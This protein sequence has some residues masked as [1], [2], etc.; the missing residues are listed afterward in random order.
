[1]LTDL[2]VLESDWVYKGGVYSENAVWLR[3]SAR[4][5]AN[6][7]RISQGFGN[8][9]AVR[10][11][12]LLSV[13]LATSLWGAGAAAAPGDRALVLTV[14][15]A[16]GP[17]TEDYVT[18]GFEQALEQGATLIVI[19][20]DT[21]GGLDGAMRGIIQTITASSIPVVTY[22]APTGARAAS[23]G[24]YIL[25]ASHVAAMA[26]GTNLGAATPVQIGGSPFPGGDKPGT[27]KPRPGEQSETEGEGGQQ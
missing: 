23:A 10:I 12:L 2:I 14:A 3:G 25:Y 13:V 17:A 19:R 20:M 24:T 15:D 6:F 18:R 16:I 11:F 26:P 21:P 22:V 7:T 1:M 27:G 5:H 8:L 9:S 4:L